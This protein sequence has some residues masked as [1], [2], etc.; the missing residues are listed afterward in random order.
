MEILGK[1]SPTILVFNEWKLQ[2]ASDKNIMK[3][4]KHFFLFVLKLFL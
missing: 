1:M 3:Y 4:Y 2:K